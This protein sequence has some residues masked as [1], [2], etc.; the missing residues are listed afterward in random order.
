M[1]PSV[2]HDSLVHK[3]AVKVAV[4]LDHA[5]NCTGCQDIMEMSLDGLGKRKIVSNKL[6]VEWAVF[7]F[8]PIRSCR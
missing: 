5:R 2:L 7:H 6:N 4:D 1:Q 8:M 3:M